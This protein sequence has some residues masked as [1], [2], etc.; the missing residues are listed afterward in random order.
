MTSQHK[1]TLVVHTGGIGDFL[2]ACPS[3]ERLSE[4]GPV[5]LLGQKDRLQ[6][7]VVGGIVETAHNLESVDFQTIFDEPSG[8]L[9]EFLASFRHVV[10]WMN[11]DDGSIRRGLESCGVQRYDI[12]PGLPPKEWGQHASAYYLDRLGMPTA[13][14]FRLRITPSET[15]HDV[16]IHPGSGSAKKNWPLERFMALAQSLDSS[17][18][19]VSWCLGPAELEFPGDEFTHVL[20]D[21]R[22]IETESLVELAGQLAASRHFIGNDSGI[23]HLSAAVGCPTVSLFGPTRPEVWAPRGIP[24]LRFDEANPE[25][26]AKIICESSFQREA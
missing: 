22:R 24:T 18:R 8:K 20:G 17:A 19:S 3:I 25:V 16:V 15:T 9:R 4:A 11:D 26:L 6:I 7:A 21:A 13:P 10:I 12:H 23:T 5:E 2:L 14:A 1:G